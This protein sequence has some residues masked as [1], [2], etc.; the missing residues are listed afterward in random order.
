MLQKRKRGKINLLEFICSNLDW[1]PPTCY[2]VI[3]VRSQKSPCYRNWTIT[4][5]I[6]NFAEHKGK[7]MDNKSSIITKANRYKFG[8]EV[9]PWFQ[10][11]SRKTCGGLSDAL[12]FLRADRSYGGDIRPLCATGWPVQ[13]NSSGLGDWVN[14]I[15]FNVLRAHKDSICTAVGL[16]CLINFTPR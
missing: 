1:Q 9:V 4:R 11:Y 15:A 14:W 6:I 7:S 10:I 13:V 2:F 5:K 3:Q 12:L 16:N 8:R